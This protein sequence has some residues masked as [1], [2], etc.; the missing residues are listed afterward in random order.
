VSLSY[1][2]NSVSETIS[3][4]V[5]V[6]ASAQ[7]EALGALS[8]TDMNYMEVL[9]EGTYY[10]T[11]GAGEPKEANVFTFSKIVIIN[12]NSTDTIRAHFNFQTN[13]Q[14]KLHILNTRFSSSLWKQVGLPNG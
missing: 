13:Q 4:P 5:V 12:K 14:L 3:V 8:I 9:D 2:P 11:G 6:P 1:Q 7:F 10:L